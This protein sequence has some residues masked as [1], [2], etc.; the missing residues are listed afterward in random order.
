VIEHIIVL[1]QLEAALKAIL[2]FYN[3][4]GLTW[5]WAIIALTVTV[6]IIILP[7]TI[8]QL[9]SMAAMQRIQPKVKTLQNQYKGKTDRESKAEMQQKLMALYKE[10]GVNPFASCLP[11]L[12][13]FPIFIALYRVLRYQ[14]HPTGDTSFLWIPNIF[15]DLNKAGTATE[16]AIIVIYILSMLGSTLLFSFV[17]DKQQ[18]Y[19]FAAMP[20]FFVFF[21]IRVPIGVCIYW[22]TTNLWT[23]GQ[24]GVVKRQ[25]G[26]HFEAIK[27]QR[28]AEQAA[29]PRT[30][31]NPKKGDGSEP[32]PKSAPAR[33]KKGR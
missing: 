20:F 33:R 9:R 7:L 8:T 22:I 24:Q 14:I 17:Q 21:I 3:D 15:V 30:S 27:K 19:M 16:V 1:D 26:H 18:K 23:I 6:R 29:K 10:E 25:M 31:R 28:A 4:H 5:A 32:K 11:L 13:Q 2:T 12:A